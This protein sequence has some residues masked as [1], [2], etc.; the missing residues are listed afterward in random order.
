MS[1]GK[2][3]MMG[4]A[5]GHKSGGGWAL[6]SRVADRIALSLAFDARFYQ[7]ENP[8]VAASGLDPAEH[9]T[10]YGLRE[11]RNLNPR[12]RTAWRLHAKAG[13]GDACQG[14]LS[15]LLQGGATTTGSPDEP[16]WRRT[17]AKD[18]RLPQAI[19]DHLIDYVAILDACLFDPAWYR[20][21]YGLRQADPIEHFL[22]SGG[23]MGFNPN[24]EFDCAAY[25][26]ANPDVAAAGVNPFLHFLRHGRNEQRALERDRAAIIRQSYFQL[27]STD[28]ERLR[29]RVEALGA[30][31][32]LISVVVPTYN[33]D[34][35]L[36]SAC[37]RSIIEGAYDAVEVIVVDDASTSPTLE[38]FL[39][40]LG[41][42][43]PRIRVIRRRENG[44]ISKATN[45]GLRNATGALIA[46]V[47]HDDELTPD[48]LL[49]VAEAAC[50]DPE[51]GVWYSD[52]VKCDDAGRNYEHFFKP[53]WSPAYLLGVMYVGHLLVVRAEHAR[54]V[55]GFD[56]AFDGVQD[57]EFMLRLAEQDVRVGHIARPLY[58][59]RAIAGSL[60]AG[61]N[62][63]S[64]ID[65][66]Q[67]QAVAAHLARL[68]RTWRV[69]S[70]PTLPHRS[71]LLPGP[72]TRTPRVSIVIPTRDQGEILDRCLSTLFGLTDY[73]DMEVIVVDNGT[74]DP[75]ALDALA[76]HPVRRIAY[77]QRFNF[78]EACN[79]G[80]AASDGG[81]LLFLNNDTEIIEP[82]WLRKLALYFE[83][84]ACAAVGPVLLY[85]DRRVQH[86]GV[87]LGARG[88]ADHVMRFFPETVDGYAGSLAC[89]REVSAIT[90]ACL[91]THRPLF[92]AVG[93]FA[94]EFAK[95]YQDVD[96]CLKLTQG[97]RRALSVGNARLIHHESV[98][99]K[100]EG[101]DRGDRALLIDRWREAIAAGDPYYNPNL[102]LQSLDYAPIEAIA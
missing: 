34:V 100:A 23:R 89:T 39:S 69:E 90:G 24:E 9:F 73:P 28:T 48:A 61:V 41:A 27:D 35:A 44:N 30:D 76:R 17:A 60:A 81:L 16:A 40:S 2:D 71:V 74:T 7:E 13:V 70:H 65:W 37:V 22:R 96:L 91:M 32:P 58:K 102:N 8:D 55:G 51:T 53:D 67:R 33:T 62:E 18:R 72:G 99:R 43:D 10:Q 85:P 5:S 45:E 88:T 54:A 63:K 87:V 97:G 4:G 57:F 11:G 3:G 77:P 6:A 38:P 50:S 46:F 25:F 14:A 36:L 31:R 49:H 29:R 95:H 52:Q 42:L 86:A 21:T 66:K 68:G 47:D 83:W 20:R 98:S 80:A 92:D 12:V 84:D 64:D 1:S 82:D 19:R 79:L 15:L 101:Y 26:D 94:T 59:W 93:G 75:V 56:P 78:A